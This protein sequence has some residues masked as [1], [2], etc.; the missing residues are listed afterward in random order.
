VEEAMS[1]E[2]VWVVAAQEINRFRGLEESP[3]TAEVHDLEQVRRML[4]KAF[5]GARVDME[6]DPIYKQIIPYL[7]VSCEDELL[8]F[9]R[10]GSEKRL[11]DLVSIG[12]GGHINP[13][14]SHEKHLEMV[15]KCARREIAEELYI[16][17]SADV[18]DEF[19]DMFVLVGVLYD[20]SN[21]VGKVHLGLVLR[22][23]VSAEVRD[24]VRLSKDENKDLE[25]RTVGELTAIYEELEGWSQICVD[26][27]DLFYDVSTVQ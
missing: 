15:K 7:I 17:G 16:E 4:G 19:P 24:R 27:L 11:T 23:E 21:E 22:C 18:F 20:D 13:V 6:V 1:H 10:A 12:L 25:W 3:I 5:F 8:S 9:T 14:D 2:M 26:A